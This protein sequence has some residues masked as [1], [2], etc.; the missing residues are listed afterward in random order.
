[1]DLPLRSSTT[2]SGLRL[3][4]DKLDV[5]AQGHLVA[6]EGNV[7]ADAERASADDA[8]GRKAKVCRAVHRE[9]VGAV[10]GDI[11]GHGLGDAFDGEVARHLVAAGGLDDR[12]RTEAHLWMPGGV[13]EVWL[14]HMVVTITIPGVE[15]RHLGLDGHHGGGEIITHMQRS[16][17]SVERATDD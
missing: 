13:E 8:R 2:R 4:T 3:G 17:E 16:T 6:H 10:E 12:R 11:E 15:G 1:V 14:Q 5:E 9:S 7:L